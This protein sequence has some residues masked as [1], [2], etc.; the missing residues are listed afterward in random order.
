VIATVVARCRRRLRFLG[1]IEVAMP[2]I[3]ATVAVAA[4]SSRAWVLPVGAAVAAVASLAWAV[5]RTPTPRQ[6]AAALDGRLGLEDSLVA[7]LQFNTESDPVS[8]LVVRDAE[9]RLS[10]VN[11]AAAFPLQIPSRSRRFT[12]AA[13]AL[14][15]AASVAGHLT[16]RVDQPPAAI[17]LRAAPS[18]DGEGPG[19]ARPAAS[20][21]RPTAAVPIPGRE[22]GT[23][24]AGV[25]ENHQVRGEQGGRRG[26]SGRVEIDPARTATSPPGRDSSTGAAGS[27]GG[28]APD[29]ATTSTGAATPGAGGTGQGVDGAGGVR[30]GALDP[31]RLP[32]TLRRRP[33]A[34]QYAA[35]RARAEAA[36]AQR[37]LPLE[38][39]SIVRDYFVAIGQATER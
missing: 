19:R 14:A 5:A 27:P 4:V 34:T 21:P 38:L 3:A 18:T 1:F 28:P 29:R 15:G 26:T 8:R 32:T 39:R 33:T 35:A 22:A 7:A 17:D 31:G 25:R 30:G 10:T 23:A 16:S 37:V 20:G 9:R 24:A 11:V 2:A 6:A 12:L 36:V 13:A